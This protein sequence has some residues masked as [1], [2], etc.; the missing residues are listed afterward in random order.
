V[1]HVSGETTP[2]LFEVDAQG[3]QFMS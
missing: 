3:K 2:W 1:G